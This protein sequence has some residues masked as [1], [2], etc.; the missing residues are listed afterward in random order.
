MICRGFHAARFGHLLG[1]VSIA[2]A[3][4]RKTCRSG[5]VL[6]REALVHRV[7]FRQRPIQ[8][9]PFV[10]YGPFPGGEVKGGRL[11]CCGPVYHCFPCFGLQDETYYP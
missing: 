5:V 2:H 8:A 1:K 3:M 10:L 6:I 7:T 11:Y 9:T 4:W